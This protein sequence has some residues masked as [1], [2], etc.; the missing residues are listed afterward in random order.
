MTVTARSSD[1]F[2]L[3]LLDDGEQYV[4]TCIATMESKLPGTLRICTK[5]L[6]F[7]P[8]DVALP[9]V[10]V[11]FASATSLDCNQARNTMSIATSA[12]VLMKAGGLDVPYA[13]VKETRDVSVTFGLVHIDVHH[14]HVYAQQMVAL[15]RLPPKESVSFQE[16]FLE[17]IEKASRFD[18]GLLREPLTERVLV[19]VGAL[20]CLSQMAKVRGKFVVGTRGVYFEPLHDLHGRGQRWVHEHERVA[21][22]LRRRSAGQDVAMEIVYRVVSK[23]SR[24][25]RQCR[26]S[27]DGTWFL[28]FLN[29]EERE[30]VFEALCDVLSSS[31]SSSPSSPAAPI[32]DT[33][34]HEPQLS[35]ATRAWQRGAM[36]NFE[37]LV[38]LNV[39]AG[40]SFN[41]LAQ[42]PV[43][44]WVLNDYTSATIDLDSPS[45]Y[46]DLS[47][48]V[49]ALNPT[50]LETF[51][52][53]YRDM[54]DLELAGDAHGHGHGHHDAHG[55]H[56]FMYGTH[57]SC[58]AY[59][60][61]WLVRV[62]P[63][64]QLRL[65]GGKFDA[66]DRLFHSVRESFV[67]VC[68]DLDRRALAH[69]TP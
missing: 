35:K 43:F 15:S 21:G 65:Q 9:I 6:F 13:F 2:S 56:A 8:D 39:A 18:C 47:K 19:E 46:R 48:P 20:L 12:Y 16:V 41:D 10:R 42:Y 61:F 30:R 3:L 31:P 64:H 55:H 59:V 14:I 45:H 11:P 24:R 53:R 23:G 32:L 27:Q 60:L 37:Y 67:S 54:K 66:P 44:P 68:I 52:Q 4:T 25:S 36:T 57:Y 40:R 29:T 33:L 17:G 58:P 63:G 34:H 26:S 49:G 22:V 62:M 51:R 69:R 38:Y 1:R 50:R 7:E 28:V 5:S